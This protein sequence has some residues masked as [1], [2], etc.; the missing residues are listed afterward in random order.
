MEGTQFFKRCRGC[1][2]KLP[3]SDGHDLCL[4]CLGEG[5]GVESCTHC[6][7]FSKRVKKNR[8]A[9]LL[10]FLSQVPVTPSP[11][12]SR[13]DLMTSVTSVPKNHRGKKSPKR[14]SDATTQALELK[15]SKPTV[16]LTLQTIAPSVS[17][18]LPA[19]RHHIDQRI[20]I[21]ESS[22]SVAQ[23]GLTTIN[24]LPP[25]SDQSSSALSYGSSEDIQHKDYRHVAQWSGKKRRCQARDPHA[26]PHHHYSRN[27]SGSSRGYC[28]SRD[29]RSPSYRRH[30][31]GTHRNYSSNSRSPSQHQFRPRYRSRRAHRSLTPSTSESPH[32]SRGRSPATPHYY[33]D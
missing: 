11:P 29:S 15:K 2:A 14:S 22:T 28:Y 25:T 17:T 30:R 26:R 27:W 5:H 21:T 32:R 13:E 3:S 9:R 7:K 1:R 18:D 6:S 20:P 24:N 10:C 31:R 19:S 16:A 4:I 33:R 8:A 12:P 23:K